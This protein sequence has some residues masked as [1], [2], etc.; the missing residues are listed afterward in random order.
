MLYNVNMIHKLHFVFPSPVLQFSLS[1]YAAE[2]QITTTAALS[3]PLAIA[4]NRAP[5]T[6]LCTDNKK[7]S[8]C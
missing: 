8:Y 4:S 6:A 3:M 2:K 7:L 5:P 1:L